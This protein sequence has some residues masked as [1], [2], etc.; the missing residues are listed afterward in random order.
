MDMDLTTPDMTAVE[1]VRQ[2]YRPERITT[3]FVGESAPFGGGFFYYGN[4]AMLRHMQRAVTPVLR[5]S[6]DFLESLKAQ[7]WYL[8]D[9]VLTPVDYLTSA[10][11]RAKCFEARQSLAERIES[12]SRRLSCPC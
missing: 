8:D 11:R 2:R 5:D 6:D 12:T 10:E 9:L 7:G 4:N 1:Q 3:L